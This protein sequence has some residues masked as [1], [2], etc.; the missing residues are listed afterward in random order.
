MSTSEYQPTKEEALFLKYYEEL[1]K[2]TTYAHAHLKLWE[3]LVDCTKEY[4]HELN[5]APHFFRL[6]MKSHLDNTILTLSRILD[7]YEGSLSIWK[8]LD[9]VEQNR[10]IFSTQ[11]FQNHIIN[12][13]YYEDLIKSHVPITLNDIQGHRKELDGL[14]QVI[15]KIKTWRDK[16]LAHLD[17]RFHLRNRNVSLQR[18]QIQNVIDTLARILNKYSSAYHASSW[19]I[20]FVSEGDFQGVMNAIRFRKVE[21]KK[22]LEAWKN[23]ASSQ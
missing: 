10:E 1:I 19:S 18:Q 14:R 3:Q 23:H 11:A 12:N 20:Q 9:L 15:D 21:H 8:F 22:Q 17:R 4:L 2:E 13:Q 6:T 5:E 16:R 7:K